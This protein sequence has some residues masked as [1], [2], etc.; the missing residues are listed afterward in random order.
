MN[1][2]R[3]VLGI[4]LLAGL[5]LLGSGAALARS[6]L[7]QP[8]RD[9]VATPATTRSTSPPSDETTRETETERVARAADPRSPRPG[10]AADPHASASRSP[11]EV[12]RIPVRPQA[13]R[14]P[15]RI[16]DVAVPERDAPAP[17]GETTSPLG[18]DTRMIP[19]FNQP[20]QVPGGQPGVWPPAGAG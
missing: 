16:S 5:V 13:P 14:A 2:P 9:P 19:R 11:T 12:Q 15:T 8:S 4:V 1:S 10:D 6:R 7:D 3:R 18:T 17:L 20:R